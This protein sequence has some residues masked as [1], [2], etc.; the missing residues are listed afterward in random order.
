MLLVALILLL[1]V[2]AGL[3]AGRWRCENAELNWPRRGWKPCWAA[4]K[5]ARMERL[6]VRERARQFQREWRQT[7]LDCQPLYQGVDRVRRDPL[8]VVRARSAAS[9]H[10]ALMTLAA[11][12]AVARQAYFRDRAEAGQVAGEGSSPG[13]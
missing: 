8:A 7:A 4:W 10:H 6:A 12:E 1:V 2:L 11:R 13:G 3:R 5:E 9:F